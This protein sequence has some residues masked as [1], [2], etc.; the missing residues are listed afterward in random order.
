MHDDI[1]NTDWP[2]I[3]WGL[4]SLFAHDYFTNMLVL[5]LEKEY[6]IKSP[7]RRVYGCPAFKWNGE[8]IVYQRP[9]KE[10]IMKTL[11]LY[12]D[13]G[14]EVYATFT[15][16]RVRE[17]RDQS[18]L[19]LLDRIAEMDTNSGVVITDRF[20]IPII[21]RRHPDIPIMTSISNIEF[22]RP[23][24]EYE[25]QYYLDLMEQFDTVN[26]HTDDI[27]RYELLEKMPRDKVQITVNE[28]CVRDCEN[29]AR[30]YGLISKCSKDPYNVIARSELEKMVCPKGNTMS[31]YYDKIDMLDVYNN[32]ASL[33][34]S[35]LKKLYDM[36]FRKFKIQGRSNSL[37]EFAFDVTR[38]LFQNGMSKILF[39]TVLG[40]MREL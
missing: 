37:E 5:I 36:G 22:N 32:D 10:S 28:N 16:D 18:S 24:E 14:I 38:F 6:G 34:R 1:I 4:S 31:S 8:D 15:N 7:I 20:L 35:E 23:D 30:H 40:R 39:Q 26:I 11:E 25:L 2:G 17:F 33:N 13:A 3:E 21:R 19:F 27:T 9:S 12:N 29:R